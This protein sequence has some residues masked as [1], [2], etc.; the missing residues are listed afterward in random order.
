L[1]QGEI[2]NRK[3]GV[4]V[5]VSVR[6]NRNL[7]GIAWGGG[8]FEYLES[9]FVRDAS[10]QRLGLIPKRSGYRPKAGSKVIITPPIMRGY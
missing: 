7:S 2:F 4:G 10:M 9:P 3:D 8:H 1:F 5:E 6:K